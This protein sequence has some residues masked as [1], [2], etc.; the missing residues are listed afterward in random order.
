MDSARRSDHYFSAPF[1]AKPVSTLALGALVVAGGAYALAKLNAMAG[2]GVGY[3]TKVACS[4]IF[5]AGRDPQ[6]VIDA[7]F[8]DISPV[9]DRA[10]LEIDAERKSVSG[11][12]LGFG[13][14]R[15]VYRNGYGCTLAR[16][17]EPEPLPALEPGADKPLADARAGT[18]AMGDDVDYAAIEA[19]IDAAFADARAATRALLVVKDGAVVAERYA[20]RFSAETPLL[21]WSMAK[22]V[23]ATMV[24]AAVHEGL[25]DIAAP[26]PV[27]EWANDKA[28]AAITWNNLLQMQS[29]LQFSEVYEDPGSDVSKMLF[30]A[31]D[32]GVVAA[33]KKLI[34]EPGTYW[35]YSS[36]TTN[37]IQ[38]TLRGTLE[39]KGAAYHAFA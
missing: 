34:R 28:R 12:V 20:G 1:R 21:S 24:G 26:A 23:T 17:G 38:R 27:G 36:G 32:A 35:D 18:P 37:L 15:A 3:M 31:R 8:N 33:K 5:L 16:G 9:L 19:A 22:S 4:E 13:R 2:V 39:A 25:L 29:G 14:S 6:V 10:R 30:R 11:S 7:E